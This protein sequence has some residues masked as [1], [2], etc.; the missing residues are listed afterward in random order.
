MY[1]PESGVTM[2]KGARVYA[3]IRTARGR[4][5]GPDF[6]EGTFH[7]D[8]VLQAVRAFV[9]ANARTVHVS[10]VWF[11]LRGS[12]LSADGL[13]SSVA[14]TLRAEVH[15]FQDSDEKAPPPP[16][17]D[18]GKV[19]RLRGEAA[20]VIEPPKP[21]RIVNLEGTWEEI[22]TIHVRERLMGRTLNSVG[23]STTDMVE[24][25]EET[26]GQQIEFPVRVEIVVTPTAVGE[27]TAEAHV[28]QRVREKR[29]GG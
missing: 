19:I 10:D 26:T 15:S 18:L 5:R 9:A 29:N 23:W 6:P 11:E 12:R 28:Y 2:A 7:R 3:W 21:K 22:G 20:G 27:F 17:E 25:V 16:N 1:Q 13:Y 4:V 14:R 8:P 24:E